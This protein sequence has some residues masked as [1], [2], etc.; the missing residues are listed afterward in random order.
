MSSVALCGRTVAITG[1]ARGIGLATD[2]AAANA[3]AQ[4]VIGDFDTAALAAAEQIGPRVCPVLLDV[5][6][7]ESFTAFLD[8]AAQHCGD[9]LDALINNAGIQDLGAL[10]DAAILGVITRPRFQVWVPASTGWLYHAAAVLPRPARDTLTR[11]LRIDRT[12]IDVDWVA[13]AVCEQRARAVVG[14]AGH[15]AAAHTGRAS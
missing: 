10:V 6:S 3:G 12:L 8:T 13:R 11:M 5:T 2:R 15:G 7:R 1:A 9:G 4:V 14:T